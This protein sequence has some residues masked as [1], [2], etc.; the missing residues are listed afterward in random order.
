MKKTIKISSTPKGK[1]DQT[2]LG[3]PNWSNEKIR[4][5]KVMVVGAGALGNEV[6]KNLTLLNV[7]HLTIVDF[8]IV[9]YNNLAKSILF[10]KEDTGTKKAIAISKNLKSINPDVRSLAIVGDISTDVGLGIFRRMDVVIGCLDNR[11]ARMFINRHCFKT[12]KFWIDGALENLSGQFDVYAPGKSCYECNLSD[13]AKDIIHFR[14]GCPDIAKRNASVGSITTTPVSSSIIA[15]FQ[16]QE[17]LKLIF[18][19][20]KNSNAGMGFKYFGMENSFIQYKLADMKEDCNSHTSY[21][22]IYEAKNLS[23]SNTISEVLDF[24]EKKF[25]TPHLKILVD[26]DIVLKAATSKHER[27]CFPTIY[28][29]HLWESAEIAKLQMDPDEHLMILEDTT[30]INRDFPFQDKA[31]YEIGIPFLDIL[32]IEANDDIHYVELTGD[33]DKFTFT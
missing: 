6:V 13:K 3:L 26:E 27:I 32:K 5:A 30:F 17:A 21:D 2:F 16:V 18:G 8:D 28:K 11:L 12:N 15:G 4:A 7:G 33:L 23:H 1:W 29:N 25:A 22:S 9:E 24:L 10:K 14:M 20:E 31:L 19:N